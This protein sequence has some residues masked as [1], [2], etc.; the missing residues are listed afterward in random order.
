MPEKNDKNLISNKN[1]G[2]LHIFPEL[3]RQKF[4][5]IFTSPLFYIISIFENLLCFAYYFR[6]VISFPEHR[7]ILCFPFLQ[8]FP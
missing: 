3:L 8:L 7:A 1:N 5:Y 6:K 4:Y 2:S